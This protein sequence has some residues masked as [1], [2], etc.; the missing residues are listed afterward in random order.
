MS[1]GDIARRQFLRTSSSTIGSL[2]IAA[3]LSDLA[4]ASATA[5]TSAEPPAEHWKTF[6]EADAA[7]S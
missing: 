4:L 2:W 6:S 1:P 5:C 7:N 3:A